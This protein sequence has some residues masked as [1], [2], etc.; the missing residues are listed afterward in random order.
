ME[1][2]LEALILKNLAFDSCATALANKVLPLPG[3]P[4]KSNPRAGARRPVNNSGLN[5]GR[6]T[7]SSKACLAV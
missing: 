5:E 6:I 4:N 7:I 2:Y 3:G 1:Y